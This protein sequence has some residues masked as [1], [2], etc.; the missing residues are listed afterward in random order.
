VA[1]QLPPAPVQSPPAR[2]APASPVLRA[3]R[4]SLLADFEDLAAAVLAELD[5]VAL[6]GRLGELVLA[7]KVGVLLA[8]GYRRS[9]IARMLEA[10]PA[11]LAH[12][13]ERVK[14]ATE[15]LDAGD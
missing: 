10:T 6:A 5:D 1:V 3:L 15:R 9:E 12:A 4:R 11:E 13:H 8:C 2:L 14:K 7:S